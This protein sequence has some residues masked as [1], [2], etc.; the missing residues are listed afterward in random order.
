MRIEKFCK[1]QVDKESGL[2]NSIEWLK[3]KIGGN[4]RVTLIENLGYVNGGHK[5]GNNFDY[6]VIYFDKKIKEFKTKKEEL[7]DYLRGMADILEKE[8]SDEIIE[9]GATIGIKEETR[10]EADFNIIYK[11]KFNLNESNT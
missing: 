4:I 6:Q 8:T 2:D 1:M 7:V 10:S 5:E 3:N 9:W 11:R